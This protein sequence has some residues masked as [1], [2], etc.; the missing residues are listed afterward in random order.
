MRKN[1]SSS[2]SLISTT[3]SIDGL[4]T[5]TY[6]AKGQICNENIVTT[7]DRAA[8]VFHEYVKHRAWTTDWL[9]YLGLFIGLL[10]PLITT[11]EFTGLTIL[12]KTIASGPLCKSIVLILCVVAGV[13]CLCCIVRRIRNRKELTC[14]Y[15][16]DQLRKD[17]VNVD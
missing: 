5:T 11:T 10:I 13:V 17:N 4:N 14:A 16:L 8:L 15:F 7:R 12:N 1:T 9:A 2:S 6:S 3:G